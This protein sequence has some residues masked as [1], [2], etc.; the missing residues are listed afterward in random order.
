[1]RSSDINI[2]IPDDAEPVVYVTDFEV[3]QP[4]QLYLIG[5][6]TSLGAVLRPL[7]E[8]FKASLV[9]PTGEI[10]TTLVHDIAEHMQTDEGQPSSSTSATSIL[11]AGRCR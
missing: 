11:L 4:Y 6:K 2:E 10:S 8:R 3:R 1:M 7:A 5:E 9:L